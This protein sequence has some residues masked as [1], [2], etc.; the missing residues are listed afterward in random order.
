MKYQ[1]F[2]CLH[3]RSNTRRRALV[4]LG[5]RGTGASKINR[6]SF[7]NDM[8]VP[9]VQLQKARKAAQAAV[10]ADSKYHGDVRHKPGLFV[11]VLPGT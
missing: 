9:A 7:R 1:C 11:V 4:Y 5:D 3:F 2:H 6:S 10:D 8:L